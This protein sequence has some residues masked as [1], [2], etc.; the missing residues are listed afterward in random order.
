MGQICTKWELTSGAL[1]PVGLLVLEEEDI[2]RHL[3]C[4]L[5]SRSSA[6]TVLFLLL[7]AADQPHAARRSV[8]LATSSSMSH[9]LCC[10]FTGSAAVFAEEARG[11]IG[12]RRKPQTASPLKY[13]H[14]H[15]CESRVK[16][17]EQPDLWR[18][19]S[20]LFS[21]TNTHVVQIHV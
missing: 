20:C 7:N 16:A 1:T 8:W 12:E 2:P 11:A 6:G 17:V 5:N 18:R 3:V 10:V 19:A 15:H 13:L 21:N 4:G 14:V 9:I